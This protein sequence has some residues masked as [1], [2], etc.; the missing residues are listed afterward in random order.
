MV[1]AQ[2]LVLQVQQEAQDLAANDKAVTV[3]VQEGIMANARSVARRVQARRDCC[4]VDGVAR[5]R[6]RSNFMS[7]DESKKK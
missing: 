4:D 5:C 3:K 2:V 6:L 7:V 1:K